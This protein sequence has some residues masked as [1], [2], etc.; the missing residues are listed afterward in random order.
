MAFTAFHQPLE[1]RAPEY[2]HADCGV[3]VKRILLCEEQPVNKEHRKAIPTA[4]AITLNVGNLLVVPMPNGVYAAV[5]VLRLAEPYQ[6]VR[7][8]IKNQVSFLV[9][10][11]YWSTLPTVSALSNARLAM[12]EPAHHT[13]NEWKGCYWGPTPADFVV[14]GSKVPN[15]FTLGVLAEP[16][17]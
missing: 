1:G 10:E 11:G 5:W 2:E 17:E 16:S 12:H 15:E 6:L 13:S 9:L 4:H 8:R 7:K 3:T 14:V